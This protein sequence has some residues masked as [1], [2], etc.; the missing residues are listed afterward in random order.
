[1][2]GV[3]AGYLSSSSTDLVVI[4]SGSFV[5]FTFLWN[6]PFPLQG[7]IRDPLPLQS[8]RRNRIRQKGRK[9][10]AQ[11]NCRPPLLLGFAVFRS[12]CYKISRKRQRNP[13]HFA[14]YS[15]LNVFSLL[16]RRKS[17]YI[18]LPNQHVKH[19]RCNER[20]PRERSVP[21]F[22]L[23]LD[24]NNL[25]VPFEDK[26]FCTFFVLSWYARAAS[27]PWASE[28]GDREGPCPLDFE[29]WHFPIK[30]L[31]K[32]GCFHSFEWVKWNLSTF[33]PDKSFCMPWKTPTIVP[34]WKKSFRRPCSS[35]MSAF[36]MHER[37]DK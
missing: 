11:G 25:L 16:E 4:R 6:I 3:G 18:F 35:R 34:P 2:P 8:V 36:V 27:L 22:G 10:R 31:G 23:P 9:P 26:T 24:F 1:M 37:L 33:P 20:W 14:K 29:G 13:P 7:G 21:S 15:A 17:V 19:Y 30:F 12:R 5:S 32:Q 28:G